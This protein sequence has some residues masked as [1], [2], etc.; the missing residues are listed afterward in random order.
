MNYFFS[1]VCSLS[2]RLENT[3]A[4]KRESP[5]QKTVNR[6]GVPERYVLR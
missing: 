5:V 2:R 6:R 3:A 1:I 4:A